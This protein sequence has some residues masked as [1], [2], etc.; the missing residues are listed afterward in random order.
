MKLK[1]NVYVIILA[2]G[3]A[4]RLKPLS[5]K[6]PK[7]L[8]DISGKTLIS[9][10]ITNFKEAGFNK[11]CIVLG[12]KNRKIKK[13]ILTDKDV[14][15]IFI[16][17]KKP[18]GMADAIA[19]AINFISQNHKNV[20]KFF[21]TAAD[22]IFLKD[23][24]LKM[25]KLHKNSD[26]ILSLMRSNDFEIARG[27]GNV[28]LSK[29]SE[30]GE[31]FDAKK[32]VIITDIIEKPKPY[33]I[34]SEYYSLP[35]YLVNQKIIPYMENLEVSKRGEK[36]FQSVLKKALL[37]DMNIRGLTIITP[38]ITAD[39]IGEYHLTSIKDIIKMNK[40]FLSGI[41]LMPFRGEQPMLI[42][43]LSIGKG[44]RFGEKIKVGPYVVIGNA[45]KIRDN[46]ELSN[47]IIYDKVSIGKKCVLENCIV[48]E[49]VNLFDNSRLKDC[50]ITLN[51]K[52][53]L[54]IINF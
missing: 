32:G 30:L 22:V 12:H 37:N 4:T 27:H 11:F 21:I 29:I 26:V 40:R 49:S 33:E 18:T 50:F 23:Q 35:L 17:Q 20:S 44:N 14:E 10:I 38:L 54:E 3:Y 34:F 2:A 47:T 53:D 48:D 36:E 13:E 25:Y 24:L 46:C 42:E 1:S 45:C 31:D 43:P 15:T 9:R 5:E 39:N 16:N 28:K 8:I 41:K 19:L 52:K 6:I 51:N 7:P